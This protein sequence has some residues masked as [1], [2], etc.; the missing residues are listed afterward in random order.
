MTLISY[1]DWI[2]ESSPATRSKTM[3]A[4]GLGPD[5]ADVFGHATPPAWIADELLDRRERD[6][7][8]SKKKKKRS[9]EEKAMTPNHDVDRV[10]DK[11]MTAAE[12]IEKEI[13]AAEKMADEIQKEL[14]RKK[15]QKAPEK[16]ST[17]KPSQDEPEPSHGDDDDDDDK[18]ETDGITEEAHWER[19]CGDLLSDP[20]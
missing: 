15:N 12:E 2:K 7:K 14:D 9:L 19:L 5:V 17:S 13:A 11:A 20:S 10:I 3:A 8:K 1:S 18:E 6:A 4:L 16:T